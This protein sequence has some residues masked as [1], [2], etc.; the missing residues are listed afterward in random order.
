[1]GIK[2]TDIQDLKL[3][4]GIARA[5]YAAVPSRAVAQPVED[6][7]EARLQE[8]IEE[9]L[10]SLGRECYYIR[11]RMD[12]ATTFRVGTSDFVGFYK[13]QPF[14]IEAKRKGRKPTSEQLGNL[15][16]AERAGARTGVVYTLDEARAIV[17]G[18]SI[19]P[20]VCDGCHDQQEF[21]QAVPY[22]KHLCRGCLED[23][24]L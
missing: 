22:V 4:E 21:V 19:G 15:L 14:A 24:R 13:G 6:Q 16:W 11:A 2:L 20:G 8:S 3:R 18:E 17:L 10:E 7:P 1:M 12:K 9:W 5:F 23:T